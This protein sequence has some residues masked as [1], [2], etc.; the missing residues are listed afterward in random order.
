ME[1]RIR[2]LFQCE[3]TIEELEDLGLAVAP[4]DHDKFKNGRIV[5][6]NSANKL[7]EFMTEAQRDINFIGDDA[8][9]YFTDVC[10]VPIDRKQLWEI[11][12]SYWAI[13]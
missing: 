6:F 5:D 12:I 11:R 1:F 10:L 2:N 13:D 8:G 3:D 9:C 7:R 4:Y